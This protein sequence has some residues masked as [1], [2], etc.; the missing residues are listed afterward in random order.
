MSKKKQKSARKTVTIRLSLE[1]HE[2]LSE[3][4]ASTGISINSFVRRTILAVHEL[5]TDK[6]SEPKMPQFFAT[7][8]VAM[9]L[10]PDSRIFK[11]SK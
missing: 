6:L 1:D 7:L 4:T 9:D 8:R 2:R 11:E 5:A 10:E 3:L